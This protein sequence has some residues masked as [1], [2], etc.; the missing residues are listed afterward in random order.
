ML[1][2]WYILSIKALSCPEKLKLAEIKLIPKG[3]DE[4][5]LTNQRPISL[6]SNLAKIYEKIIYNR[7]YSFISKHKILSEKQFGF[8]K[9][10]VLKML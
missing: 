5:L 8:I 3:G 6:I 2:H 9:N 4:H 1:T 7:I 10:L